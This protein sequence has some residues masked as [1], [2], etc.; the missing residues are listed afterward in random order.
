MTTF[1]TMNSPTP[2]GI[3]DSDADFPGDANKMVTFE[4]ISP[5]S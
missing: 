4:K 2:F 5:V 3:Y 1:E